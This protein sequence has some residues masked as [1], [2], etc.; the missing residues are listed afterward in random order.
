MLN[1]IFSLLFY[2]V[3]KDAIVVAYM[4]YEICYVVARTYYGI[5]NV[6]RDASADNR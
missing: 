4:C 2:Y 6:L 1:I 3:F 5:L